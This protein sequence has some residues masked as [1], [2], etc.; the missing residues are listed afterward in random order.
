MSHYFLLCCLCIQLTLYSELPF[1]QK[2]QDA[3]K[4]ILHSMTTDEK[5]GQLFIVGSYSNYK[6][7]QEEGQFRNPIEYAEEAIQKYHVGSVL[8]K[9]YWNP[10]ELKAQV[11]YLRS[12]SKYTLLTFQDMEWGLNMRHKEISPLP[13][14]IAMG[15]IQNDT[16]IYNIGREIGKQAQL[17]GIDCPLCPVVDVNTPIHPFIGDRSFG[18]NPTLVAKKGLSIMQGLTDEGVIACAKH[19]PGH[20]ATSTNSH[21]ALPEI[22]KNKK[23]LLQCDLV[24]FQTLI[25]HHIPMIITAHILVPKIENKQLPATLSPSVV[26]TLLKQELHFDGIVV[27]DDLLMKAISDHFPPKQAVRMAF[28]A[29][30]D[31]IMNS[32]D[33]DVSVESIKEGL[34]TGEISIEELD[35]KVIKIL[36]LKAWAKEQREKRTSVPL[37][38]FV[39]SN[40]PLRTQAF[41]QAIVVQNSFDIT[42][43]TCILQIGGGFLPFTQKMSLPSLYLSDIA[44]EK[45]QQQALNA[46]QQY[47]KVIVTLFPTS[48]QFGI[49]FGLSKETVQF[50]TLLAQEKKPILYVLFGSPYARELIGDTASIVYAFS[51]DE[52]AQTAAADILLKNTKAVGVLPFP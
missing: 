29:G 45:Q 15:A 24:P 39:A 25:D 4:E 26:T 14:N 40:E 11:D 28:K 34:S 7:A 47:E 20:G 17:V 18:T 13:K 49:N 10:R 35:A 32:K 33:I 12:C 3:A 52:A 6:D 30:C 38:H 36:A 2:Y 51:A 44:T 48:A 8:F 19:F 16:L 1:D 43:T 42:S 50:L 31:L 46:L 27:T 41:E 22:L 21:F 5:V 37:N 9:Y 23:E